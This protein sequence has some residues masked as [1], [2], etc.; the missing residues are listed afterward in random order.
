MI[1]RN[2]FKLFCFLLS[3]LGMLALGLSAQ[4]AGSDNND[5]KLSVLYAQ[6]EGPVSPASVDFLESA[7]EHASAQGAQ[8]LLLRL[9]TPGGLVE[10]MRGMVKEI[11]NAPM[12]V[13]IWVGPGG[14]HA[15]S[16][17]VFLVAASAVAAMS[18]GATI[19]AASPVSAEGKDVPKTMEK[20][21][22]NDL[23]SL[24]RGLAQKHGRKAAWYEKAV[25]ESVSI[26]GEEAV[27][28]K[29]VEFVAVSPED[30]LDQAGRRGV[31]AQGQDLR[32]TSEQVRMIP[33]EPGVR[34]RFLAWLLH[35]Q[36]AYFLLIGG[37]AGLFFEV[38]N[39]GAVLPG[40]LGGICLLLGLYAL[41]ILPTNAAGVLL[42]LLGIV[43]FILEIKITSYGMLSV[44]ALVCL[45]VGSLILFKPGEG[46]DR[47]P[48]SLIISTVGTFGA[49]LGLAVYLVAKAM[50]RPPASGGEAMVGLSAVIRNWDNDRGMVLV[51]GELWKARTEITQPLQQ[52]DEVEV[53]ARDGLTL[54]I[55]SGRKS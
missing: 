35:P 25:D 13:L 45:F 47:L 34:Y 48:L 2:K 31:P 32:F 9:D 16:A 20:K 22:K 38:T 14:A 30:F 36:I 51:R 33:F 4:G 44:A 7:V 29:V 55:T 27:L 39:A 49:L 26:T 8:L 11:V 12:P 24:V 40:V 53:V 15:A 41:S 6:L 17:G 46:F 3:L 43:F 28:Q 50:R 19:G 18:P 52:G 5:Q 1:F 23:K 37:I 10:S 54:T 42:L 21:I